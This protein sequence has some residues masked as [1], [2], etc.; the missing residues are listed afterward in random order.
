MQLEQNIR[1]LCARAGISFNDFL[2]DMD[3]DHVNEL[4]VYDLEAVAEEYETDLHALLFKQVALTPEWQQKLDAIRLLILDVD[5]VMTDGGMYFAESGDQIKRY[6]TKDGMAIRHLTGSDFNVAII[7]SGFKPGMVEK[8]AEVLGIQHCVVT[9]EPKKMILEELCAKIGVTLAETAIIGDDINDLEV[10]QAVGFSACPSDAMD[11][12]K[13][14]VDLILRKKGGHGCIREF[15]DN[16]LLKE[17]L[18]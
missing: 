17:P 11:V 8:R 7:S 15:I 4:T 9:R 13:A 12:V 2:N 16:Y 6:D 1:G 5:G 3:V 14:N 18:K 10:I